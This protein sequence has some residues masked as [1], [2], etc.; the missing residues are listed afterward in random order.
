MDV[1]RA[2]AFMA[3]YAC[4]CMGACAFACKEV[5]V[6]VWRY[7]RATGQRVVVDAASE[8]PY[9]LGMRSIL[10]FASDAPVRTGVSPACTA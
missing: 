9:T 2:R 6:S 7:L 3:G 4:G 5:G 8:N 1:C 10:V